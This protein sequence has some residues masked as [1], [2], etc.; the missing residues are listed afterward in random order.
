MSVEDI[1]KS[2][3][4]K[5]IVMAVRRALYP[6]RLN[7]IHESVFLGCWQG[8]TYQE[9]ADDLG[10]DAVY[11]R[12]IGSQLWQ[13]LS[14]AFG[15]KVTKSNFQIIVEQYLANTASNSPQGSA[16]QNPAL[17]NPALQKT[18]ASQPET[19]DLRPTSDTV[20]QSSAVGRSVND[21]SQQEFSRQADQ[22][23]RVHERSRPVSS[24][25]GTGQCAHPTSS[26][27]TSSQT[28][29]VDY[30]I[31]RPP[32]EE[33]CY[34]TVLE[35]G[36]LIRIKAPRQMG[37]TSLM[38]KILAHTK[39]QTIQTVIVSLRLA[40]REVFSTLDRFLQW[41]CA[42][43]DDQL[44]LENTAAT[45]WKPIFGSNY[46]CTHY[47]GQTLLPQVQTSVMVALD[48]V[49]VLF[50]HT[51]IATDFL[52]LLRAWCEKAKNSDRTTD[53]WWKLK[54]LVVHSTEV[55]IPLHQHQSPF[56]IGLSIE[57]P[58]FTPEQVLDL[59]CRYQLNWEASEVKAMM[60]L[61]GGKPD[62]IRLTLNWI[63]TQATTLDEVL[64]NAIA[65]N[66]IY[67][68]HLRQQFRLMQKY[69]DL[70]PLLKQVMS[71]EGISIGLT[72]TQGFQL[73]SLGLVKLH[74]QGA[75]PSCELYRQ[76]F[77][78]LWHQ[79]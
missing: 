77:R 17:Q 9:I 63:A 14:R 26:H 12:G 74:D 48:D 28:P 7:T 5:Q 40:D 43:V 3:R 70:M 33:R 10:Y 19:A 73:E 67:Y 62:L 50:E 58:E 38:T 66:G 52:G 4:L 11:I 6:K 23:G 32:I 51:A 78:N 68:E 55:Y 64:A 31:P 20:G 72:P 1:S 13:Q 49:D 53:A 36:A 29:E 25:E 27:S 61:V 42:I 47:F 39:C 65:P 75:S 34:G 69:P 57:L 79:S 76:Y 21:T 59:A 37:K 30:Y 56:N 45:Q 24:M 16:L 15:E 54:L 60:A 71:S 35:Q 44:G 41:F 22:L 2:D 46:N 8:Q 18:T